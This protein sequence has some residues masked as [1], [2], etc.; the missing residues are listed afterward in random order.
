MN[1]PGYAGFKP[2]YTDLG[3]QLRSSCLSYKKWE[4]YDDFW[5]NILF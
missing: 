3:D 4:K 5:E 2:K 1:L